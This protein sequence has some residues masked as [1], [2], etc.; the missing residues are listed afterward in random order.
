MDYR[1]IVNSITSTGNDRVHMDVTIEASSDGKATWHQTQNGHR[2]AV[3]NGQQVLAITQGAGTDPEKRA[4]L[5]ALFTQEVESW[6][7]HVSDNAA[8]AILALIPGGVPITVE[9]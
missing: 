4:A 8:E 6:G 9:L 7:L 5:L 2:T 1:Y 3:L